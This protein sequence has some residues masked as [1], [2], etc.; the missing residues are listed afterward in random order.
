V[1]AARRARADDIPRLAALWRAA[2]DELGAQVRGG[3]LFVAREA[4]AEPVDESLGADIASDDAVVVAGTLD[5]VVVGVAAGCVEHLRDGRLLGVIRELFV[6]ADARGVAV[7]EAMM[8]ELLGW[9]GEKGCVGVDA[10]ALPGA[11]AT[12][13]FFEGSGFS[14]RLLVMHH[15]LGDGD[16]DGDA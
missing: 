5:D 4:R 9:F 15:R 11:R 6:E 14:A 16:V 3:S 13:N 12:K 1:E 10:L 7:G 2:R 8:A